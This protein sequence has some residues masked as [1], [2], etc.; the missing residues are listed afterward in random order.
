MNHENRNK[1]TNE[2]QSDESH[3]KL[4][5]A[6]ARKVYTGNIDRVIKWHKVVNYFCQY[7]VYGMY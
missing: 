6:D 4:Y 1:E 2:K 5:K 7:E 3:R